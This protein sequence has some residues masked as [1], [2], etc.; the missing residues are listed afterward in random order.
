MKMPELIISPNFTLDDIRKIR[1]YNYEMTKNM[2][3]QEACD[4]HNKGAEPVRQEIK[5]MRISNLKKIFSDEINGLRSHIAKNSI[6]G[7]INAASILKTVAKDTIDTAL[8][9]PA[10][11]K[12]Y[13]VALVKAGT[14]PKEIADEFGADEDDIIKIVENYK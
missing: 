1:D 3:T 13:V 7:E 8:L 2:T 11:I 4:Y 9:F 12:R 5:T 6:C 10:D 14:P